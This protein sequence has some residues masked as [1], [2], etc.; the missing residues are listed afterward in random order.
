MPPRLRH[1]DLQVLLLSPVF[2]RPPL[3][4]LRV[5]ARTPVQENVFTSKTLAKLSPEPFE[6]PGAVN[7]RLRLVD[8]RGQAL[9]LSRPRGSGARLDYFRPLSSATRY[10]SRPRT[11]GSDR[12]IT[13][14]KDLAT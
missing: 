14:N 6:F 10:C 3:K 7:G 13:Q 4:S 8:R 5:T 9:R 2:I 1:E 12:E 11:L